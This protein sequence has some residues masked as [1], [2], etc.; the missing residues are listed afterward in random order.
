MKKVKIATII[1]SVILISLISFAGV[2]IQKQNR[3]ENQVK[4]YELGMSLSGYRQY[5]VEPKKQEDSE[6]NAIE[7]TDEELSKIKE[8]IETRLKKMGATEYLIRAS[9]GNIVIELKE[10]KYTD[11]FLSNVAE[12]GKFEIID[13]KTKEVLMTNSD[14]KL[15]NVLYNSTQSGT[16]VYLNIEF[17]E[18]GKSK[19]EQITKTY[20]TT[21]E[22][23]K[24]REENNNFGLD[25][26]TGNS[27]AEANED[28]NQPKISMQID[29]NEILS[30]SFDNPI[31]SGKIQVALARATTDN[32]TLQENIRTT[33]AVAIILD[34]EMLPREYEV[35]ENE[36]VYSDITSEMLMVFSIIIAVIVLIALAIL[37]VKNKMRGL[38]ASALYIGLIALY[39][40]II[41][42]TNVE[43]TIEGIAGILIILII[44][45]II[46]LR[47]VQ[48]KKILQE[49]LI[50]IAIATIAFCFIGWSQIASLGMVMFW[51]AVTL[52][53]HM[54]TIKVLKN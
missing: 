34:N 16:I 41:R 22:T 25:S 44:N 15:S 6:G 51:G 53:Y 11:Y 23:K 3:M 17:T 13:K 52:I 26:L 12:Q 4:E 18:E 54:I 43:L 27:T 29:G 49:D 24:K 46:T 10:D 8:I 9:K 14:L 2:Y 28:L 36:Y 50:P 20:A 1:L 37:V 39:L 35:K 42:Y 32:E 5:M 45:Y 48:E 38:I 19:F 47:I 21:E 40:L 33:S 30:Q 7:V 31:T